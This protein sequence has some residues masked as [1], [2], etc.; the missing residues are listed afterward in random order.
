MEAKGDGRFAR[1]TETVPALRPCART[2]GARHALGVF[3]E[4][5][6]HHL[7]HGRD[8]GVARQLIDRLALGQHVEALAR[9]LL[10]RDL[11]A[12]EREEHLERAEARQRVEQHPEQ[13]IDR[14]KQPGEGV[15]EHVERR[16][17]RRGVRHVEAFEDPLEDLRSERGP[18]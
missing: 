1:E 8:V 6:L 3:R 9:L 10:A 18:T 15:D 2:K 14:P 5:E 11:A 4:R 16:G 13:E 17:G 7:V 12:D